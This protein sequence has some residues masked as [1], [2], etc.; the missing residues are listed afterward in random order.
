MSKGVIGFIQYR[1]ERV[2][3]LH[4]TLVKV[5]VAL[6]YYIPACRAHTYPVLQRS[7]PPQPMC[8]MLP[9][10]LTYYGVRSC[11]MFSYNHHVP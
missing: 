6:I 11:T 1:L 9:A 3:N 2:G 10:D 4:A 8:Q 7:A 5:R